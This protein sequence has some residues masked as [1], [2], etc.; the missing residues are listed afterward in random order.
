MKKKETS[1]ISSNVPL[2]HFGSV[3]TEITAAPALAYL[4]AISKNKKIL[5]SQEI[6]YYFIRIVPVGLE[7]G[8][9][10]PLLGDA[11]LNSAAIAILGNSL[12]KEIF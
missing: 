4:Q 11:L 7:C 8:Q 5:I 3:K 9:M 10:S 6:R 1:N 2:N 12:I